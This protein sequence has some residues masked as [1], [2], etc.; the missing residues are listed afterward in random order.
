VNSY[1]LVLAAY[2]RGGTD[3]TFGLK[4]YVLDGEFYAISDDPFRDFPS[5]LAAASASFDTDFWRLPR[6]RFPY[7]VA[8]LEALLLPSFYLRVM[9]KLGRLIGRPDYKAIYH[10]PSVRRSLRAVYD[11]FARMAQLR[12]I[13]A[14]IAFIPADGRDQTNGLV[15]I[16]AATELQR[17]HV[18]FINVGRDFEW[19]QFL[20]GPGCHPSP[21]GYR[22]IA[23]DVA[24]AVAPLLTADTDP[25]SSLASAR[26]RC[27]RPRSIGVPR[28]PCEPF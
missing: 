15:A 23:A 27:L 16:Q 10:L 1:R 21:A 18:T 12:N 20:L 19:S 5:M 22:M 4:P 14:V 11:R 2:N 26:R 28:A 7:S 8:A 6:A 9:D 24:R 25:S 17:K 13:H 3:I